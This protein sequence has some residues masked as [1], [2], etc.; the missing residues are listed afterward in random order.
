MTALIVKGV[1]FSATALFPMERVTA[2]TRS[3]AVRHYAIP[4][5]SLASVVTRFA[6]EAGVT[7][8]FE[9]DVVAG[10]HSAGLSGSYP[11]AGGLQALL[12]G[13]GLQAVETAAQG[14]VLV[15]DA[16]PAGSSQA[17][18]SP[19][20]VTQLAPVVVQASAD[21]S[22]E[23]LPE[24]FAG[25]Q[26]ARGSRVGLLGNRDMMETPFSTTAYTADLIQDQQARS[27]ADV[28]QNDASVRVARGFGNFQELY[29]IRGFPVF[30]DDMAYNGLYGLLPRQY[31]AAELSERVEILRGANTFVN[32]ATSGGGGVGGSINV[33]PKRAPNDALSRVTAGLEDGGQTYVAADIA[34]RFGPDQDGGLRINAARRDGETSIDDE[35]RTLDVLSL[36]ADFR[37]D[38]IRLSADIGYQDHR[39]DAPRPSVTPAGAIPDA[40]DARRNF[41][42]SWTYSKEKQVFGTV[43]GEYDLTDRI[44]GWAAFGV[45]DGDEDNLLA[46]PTVAEDGTSFSYRFDNVRKDL[47][48]TGEAGIRGTAETGSVT[49]RWVVSATRFSQRSRNAYAL[50]DFINGFSG[51]IFDHQDAPRPPADFFT[52]GSMSSPHLTDHTKTSSI[53]IA[54]TLGFMDERLLLTLGVRQQRI[55]QKTYD[56]NTRERSSA[57]DESEVTPAVGVV[58]KVTP[59]VSAYANYMEN[60]AKGDIAPAMVGNQVVANAGQ[61]LSPY[62]A[63][64]YEAG[65]KYDAGSFGASLAAFSIEKPFGMLQ[66]DVFRAA[67]EQRNRGIELNL[68]GEPLHGV[69]VLSG[70]VFLDAEQRKTLEGRYDGKKVI[71]VPDAQYNL[72]VEW[73]VPALRGLTLN[74]R[75]VHTAR[76]YANAANTETIPAWT[77]LDLGARYVMAVGQQMLTV[78]TRVENVTNGD[79][80]VSVGGYPDANY[81]VLGTPRTFWLTATLDF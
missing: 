57:Y 8:S 41:A 4:A 44:T 21:A 14:F 39:I 32:G 72:G 74:G 19:E 13:T 34:R 16:A 48:H 3:G 68:Y 66:G 54:D 51:N 20:S 47:V 53:A 33:V 55:E 80:W 35:E 59:Q 63:E 18:S 42:Q 5:G 31:I 22:A 56:Y 27:V 52:G 9:P 30:S 60:L 38:R 11:V 29:V 61:A 50:S 26:V 58:F 10:K 36:G 17:L 49:H 76:Q 37:T 24:L 70:A 65:L 46:N 69:R 23:G 75:V 73:D 64:Q 7:V 28:V 77:R 45:R 12:A 43:R 2:Q 1:V 25:R 78:R 81:L 67:G 6:A 62:R 79:H 71:G 40:P 15:P